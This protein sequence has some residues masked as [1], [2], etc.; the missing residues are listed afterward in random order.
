LIWRRADGLLPGSVEEVDRM[1]V[2]KMGNRP[3]TDAEPK[4]RSGPG[5]WQPA[6][7]SKGSGGPMMADRR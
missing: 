2:K 4:M 1:A 6:R 7:V 3:L 5:G